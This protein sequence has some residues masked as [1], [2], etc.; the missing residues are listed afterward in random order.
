MG[1]MPWTAL[2]GPTILAATLLILPGLVISLAGGLRG[3]AAVSYAPALSV[4]TISV[5]ALATGFLNVGWGW[6]VVAVAAVV[7]ALLAWGVSVALRRLFAA[8]D[9]GRVRRSLGQRLRDEAPLW[10]GLA[11]AF[12][13]LTR[14]VRNIL[15]RPDAFSQ[16]FDNIFHL[17]AIR[18]IFATGNASPF[19]IGLMTTPPGNPSA[20]Y[21][22]AFHDT[23]SLVMASFP[24]TVTLPTNGV[25]LVTVALIWPLSCLALVRAI[26]PLSWPTAVATGVLAASFSAFPILLLD[27]GVLYPNLFG[28]A[29]VPALMALVVQG[30]R[31]GTGE[32]LEPWRAWCFLVASLPGLAVAH[33][34]TLMT[35]V[36]IAIPM[37]VAA[38]WRTVVRHHRGETS[39]R[40]LIVALLAALV[41]GVV[42]RQLWV[43]VRPDEAAATWPPI[44]T[45]PS[46]LGQAILNAPDQSRAAWLVSLVALIGLL[47]VRR[48]RLGWL[49]A[50]WGIIVAL[51]LVIA[52]AGPTPFRTALVGIWYNDPWRFSATLPMVALPLAAVG[53]HRVVLAAQ[54]ALDRHRDRVGVPP[55]AVLVALT[56]LVPG[57]LVA[58]TQRASYMNEAVDNASQI[59]A[60]TPESP[61]VT[62]D[63]YAILSLAAEQV[64]ADAVVATNPWNGSSMA[65]ALKGIHTT[66]TH[67]LYTA[68]PDL[69]IVNESLDEAATS[70]ATCDA[71]DR[72]DVQYALDFGDREVH[73]A[74]HPMPGF[75]SL[76]TARGFELVA[77]QGDAALFRI[78]ACR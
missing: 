58:G 30:F 1:G 36:A 64:P 78:T 50:S 42:I 8:P 40:T 32:A 77:E 48:L 44:T 3:F 60:L 71:L 45:I 2:L 6:P 56:L 73:G 7:L 55:A 54:D 21:P 74:H 9:A 5:A 69:E 13:L 41:T 66:T 72:L 18:Y 46:A 16:T 76:G 31:L 49:A 15:D 39:T 11:A 70:P 57:I 4:T 38:L 34:N 68:S 23:A 63:E 52:G 59:Y 12:V 17:S 53:V 35:L 75:D 37:I 10:V 26:V 27:F 22:T 33:P 62:T 65:W 14:H 19:D 29:L 24:D 28:L 20:F 43:Y 51:W 67:V 61:L 47:S 25:L